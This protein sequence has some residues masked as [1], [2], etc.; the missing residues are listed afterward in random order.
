MRRFPRAIAVLV[1]L[2]TGLAL[3][4]G[5]PSSGAAIVRNPGIPR[6]VTR[7]S[8]G[9]QGRL[10][11]GTH[12]IAFTNLDAAPLATIYLRLWSNGVLGCG[13]GSI[14]ISN[15]KGGSIA[16]TSQR[17]TAVE[18]TLDAPI[19]PG[20]RAAI[21]MDLAIAVPN[22]NDRFGYHRGLALVGTALPTLAI[23]DQAG[24]HLDPFVNLG[25]SFYSIVGSY[26]VALETPLALDTPT[27]GVLVDR[28]SAGVGRETRTYAARDVRDFVWAAGHLRTMSARSGGTR[29]VVSFQP[30][31]VSDRTAAA[32]LRDAVRSM[33]TF[34]A[35]FGSF[36]YPEM[37][38]VLAG[39]AT[40]G[41]MEYPTVIFTDTARLTISHE[42]AHQWWYGIVGD[43]EYT[44]P[45][46]DESFATWSQYLPFSPWRACKRY[47]F[48]GAGAR[49]TNDMGY[50]DAH[51]GEYGTIYGGGGCLLANLAHR[52]GLR[53]FNGIL[54]AYAARHWLGV[55]RT[56]KFK[57]RIEGAAARWLP[58]LDMAAYWAE[59]RVD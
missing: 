45:W 47:L 37:D 1:V 15:L 53:R 57:A 26:R 41:G 33:Q 16:A 7:L 23:H 29:V 2:T 17:C 8:T 12:R 58:G 18:V 9:S 50:W 34:S 35:A 22:E 54:R 30:Q 31:A 42:L 44:E 4:P 48:P 27:T 39:H 49:I 36:P 59:W 46:L 24:W 25:E 51:R 13:A 11:T 52:F 14:Q 43:D 32:R 21:S 6:Y 55:A 5:T 56:A 28:T 40:F 10:W 3:T 19:A 38:V 20:E